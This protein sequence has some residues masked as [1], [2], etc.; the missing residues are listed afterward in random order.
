MFLTRLRKDVEGSVMVEFAVIGFLLMLLVL[1]LFDFMSM[2]WQRNMAIKAVERGARIAAVSAPVAG[3]APGP[4]PCAPGSLCATYSAVTGCAP[5]TVPEPAGAFDCVCNGAT[6]ACTAGPAGP[7]AVGYN[8][9]AM[10][11]I[12]TG[13]AGGGCGIT[14]KNVDTLG[15]CDLFP[16]LTAANVIVEYSATGLGFCSRPQGPVPT[17]TVSLQNMSLRSIFLAGVLFPFAKPNYATAKATI[18]GE[19]LSST[20]P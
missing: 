20:W 17:I 11:T 19:N 3:N 10:N 12:V 13:R 14:G 5:G 4:L 7:C 16:T 8:A 18:T 6:G 9:A 15:M 2:F 1:G